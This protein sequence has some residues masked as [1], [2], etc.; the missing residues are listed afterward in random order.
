MSS[1]EKIKLHYG[2][3]GGVSNE[4]LIDAYL[5][6][7]AIHGICRFANIITHALLNNNTVNKKA[8]SVKGANTYLK[9]ASKGCF[10]ET[11]EIHILRKTLD[12]IGRASLK[13]E[14]W[15]LSELCINNLIGNDYTP[16][17]PWLKKQ[18]EKDDD[19]LDVDHLI[20]RTEAAFKD[21]LIPIGINGIKS[22]FI[23]D[24]RSNDIFVFNQDTKMYVTSETTQQKQEWITGN[25]TRLSALSKYGRLYS[26]EEGRVISF[27]IAN[28]ENV[29]IKNILLT[30][31]KQ[32]INNE[33]AKL[34]LKVR[35]VLSGVGTVKKYLIDD[36][37]KTV[38]SQ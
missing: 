19:A 5:G 32:R 38:K 24:A 7:K 15:D 33:P 3:E 6:S 20:F 21:M 27:E 22:A 8:K 16:Q 30:S 12:K 10:E 4:G 37:S 23:S 9:G 18:L 13:N 11:L 14:F 28:I 35:K 34:S 29:R 2:T 1:E 25:A 17:T 26:D 36:I 31:L